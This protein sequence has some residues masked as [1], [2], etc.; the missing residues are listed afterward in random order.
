MLFCRLERQAVQVESAPYAK[1]TANNS[2]GVVEMDT[3][4]NINPNK[5]V[6][7][8]FVERDKVIEKLPA[9]ISNPAFRDFTLPRA[10]RA[11]APGF[12][13]AG[14]KQVVRLVPNLSIT[15][16]SRI[17]IRAGF[18]EC[19]PQL[20]DDPGAGRMSMTLK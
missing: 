3:Q 7:R 8:R 4:I 6:Q 5:P 16:E 9:P 13:A 11:Y 15:T 12:H 2:Q 10:C 17:A 14:C 18:R 20:L 1:L 19:F